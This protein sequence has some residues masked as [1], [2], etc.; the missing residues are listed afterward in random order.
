MAVVL[1][2]DLALGQ[3]GLGGL[4]TRSFPSQ[5]LTLLRLRQLLTDFVVGV[6]NALFG[7]VHDRIEIVALLHARSRTDTVEIHA[8][9]AVAHQR[10]LREG[11]SDEAEQCRE[12]GKGNSAAKSVGSGMLHGFLLTRE[13][14]KVGTHCAALSVRGSLRQARPWPADKPM[15]KRFEP[16]CAYSQMLQVEQRGPCPQSE[17]KIDSQ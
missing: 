13:E 11:K 15:S 5:A 4:V 16:A 1:T 3:C 12:R 14:Q 7:L 6:V 17:T 8:I 10:A 9:E 2:I